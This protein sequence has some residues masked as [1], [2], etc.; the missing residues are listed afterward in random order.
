MLNELLMELL[1]A[2]ML[3]DDISRDADGAIDVGRN[4]LAKIELDKD[5]ILLAL[6]LVETEEDWITVETVI[7]G[8]ALLDNTLAELVKLLVENGRQN[9]AEWSDTRCN[10][11]GTD[12]S[13]FCQAS[14]RS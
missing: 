5:A 4:S 1:V 6:P 9:I 3:K 2:A 10:R 12:W 11:A 7:L 14:H 13:W 8:T